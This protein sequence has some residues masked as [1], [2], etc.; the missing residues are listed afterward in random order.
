MKHNRIFI[1][2]I[3]LIALMVLTSCNKDKNATSGSTGTDGAMSEVVAEALPE[4]VAASV[5]GENIYKYEVERTVNQNEDI[6][7]NAADVL[8]DSIRML[9]VVQYG[10][11]NGVEV[12]ESELKDRIVLYRETYESIYQR[13]IELYGETDFEKGLLYRM[14]YEKTKCKIIAE[15]YE[16]IEADKTNIAAF[17]KD[18]DVDYADL[19][20]EDQQIAKS[21][22][23]EWYG[24]QC[25][26]AFQ[27]KLLREADIVRNGC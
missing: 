9:V 5:N 3:C 20:P 10:R 13:A 27:D 1:L 16:A 12:S 6:E 7:V 2:L 18:R 22:Y 8:E 4:D 25:F 26:A 11:E 19:S 14:L 17:C 24:K 15:A 21:A 23:M